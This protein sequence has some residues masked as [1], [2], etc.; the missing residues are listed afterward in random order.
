MPVTSVAEAL[1]YH[2]AGARILTGALMT[3]AAPLLFHLT[4]HVLR[5]QFARPTHF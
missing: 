4:A 3:L 1:A 2:I 5:L